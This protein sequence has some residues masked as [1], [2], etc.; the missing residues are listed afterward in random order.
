M[1]HPAV[2][3]P[4]MPLRRLI[5]AVRAANTRAAVAAALLAGVALSATMVLRTSEGLFVGGTDNPGN[6]WTT[7]TVA[8]SDDAATALFS[9][10][11]DGLLTGGQVLTRCIV[12]RYDGTLT[13]ATSVKLY[14]TAGGDLADH[15]DVTIDQGSG[16]G[17]GDCTG[18]TPSV[19][20]IFTGTL[21]DLATSAS[22]F[23]TGVG[24]WAPAA[25]GATMTYRFTVTV[26]VVDAAQGASASSTFI[27][28]AQG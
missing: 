4:V 16:G 14:A 25:T 27:W 3:H 6:S 12:V 28:E 2:E 1:V 9:T 26:Q 22:G 19:P 20:G 21:A 15:L 13:G 8:L 11:S 10:G 5:S 23:S 18:F 24:S 17:G 7:G